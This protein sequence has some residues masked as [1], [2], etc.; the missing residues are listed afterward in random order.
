MAGGIAVDA[1]RAGLLSDPAANVENAHRRSRR[2]LCSA[3]F[4]RA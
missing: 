2:L 1:D 4:A 3:D